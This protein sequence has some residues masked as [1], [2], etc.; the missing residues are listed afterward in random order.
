MPGRRKLRQQVMPGALPPRRYSGR[1]DAGCLY[2]LTV[3]LL[4]EHEDVLAEFTSGQVAV[5]QDSD[6]GGWIEVS[7]QGRGLSSRGG[8]LGSPAVAH[9]L[10]S[11]A[12]VVQSWYFCGE[13][14]L[15][16]G[17]CTGAGRWG[18]ARRA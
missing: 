9:R 11:G 14:Q 5:P 2:E 4:S 1:T 12:R 10:G 13:T 16:T 8:T 6:D 18:R 3:S 15:E 17:H 7:L